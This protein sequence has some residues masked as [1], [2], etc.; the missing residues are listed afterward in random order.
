MREIKGEG[1]KWWEGRA[2]MLLNEAH[3]TPDS[4]SDIYIFQVADG[5][6]QIPYHYHETSI[7]RIE[8]QQHAK[9]STGGGMHEFG[10]GACVRCEG[11]R[12]ALQVTDGAL[13]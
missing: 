3:G 9:S 1:S 10:N 4:G 13:C 2:V 7:E 6:T 11:I 8:F 5:A 12:G